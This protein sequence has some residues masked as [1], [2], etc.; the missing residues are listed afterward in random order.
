MCGSAS[1]P[2]ARVQHTRRPSR[3]LC[4]IGTCGP[5]VPARARHAGAGG[6]GRCGVGVQVER[7]Y[8]S[9]RAPPLQLERVTPGGTSQGVM[10]PTTTRASTR[11]TPRAVLQGLGAF[12]HL[13][14]TATVIFACRQ[15][16]NFA[17]LQHH[18]DCR[19]HTI[20]YLATV[21]IRYPLQCSEQKTC[22]AGAK[23]PLASSAQL[24]VCV[25]VCTPTICG[26]L[27][28]GAPAC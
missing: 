1:S 21:R 17:L 20:L 2:L 4:R 22:A 16:S 10:Q 5:C 7:V 14:C 23:Y 6:R 15:P 12:H 28:P 11:S 9:D 24:R 19:I 26:Y 13:T 27:Q 18:R 8:T 25:Y 3:H